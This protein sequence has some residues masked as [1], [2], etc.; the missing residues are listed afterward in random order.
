VIRQ[1][2]G[3]TIKDSDKSKKMPKRKFQEIMD[4]KER[5]ENL[6]HKDKKIEVLNNK[7]INLEVLKETLNQIETSL[8]VLTNLATPMILMKTL[9]KITLTQKKFSTHFLNNIGMNM[10]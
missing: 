3:T 8:T 9:T 10:T 5:S 6:N 4:L 7:E 1:P 2:D